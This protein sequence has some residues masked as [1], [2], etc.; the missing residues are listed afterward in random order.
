MEWKTC[1]CKFKYQLIVCREIFE[2]CLKFLTVQ[3]GEIREHFI[4]NIKKFVY[5][6]FYK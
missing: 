2:L 4:R 1:L 3:N 6:I 5:F